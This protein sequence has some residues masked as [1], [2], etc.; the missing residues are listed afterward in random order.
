[1]A[2]M[3]MGIKKAVK[4]GG[5]KVLELGK[6]MI[7]NVSKKMKDSTINTGRGMSFKPAP[8][9]EAKN[10]A[11]KLDHF[12]ETTTLR[13][14][15]NRAAWAKKKNLSEYPHTAK[16]KNVRHAADKYEKRVYQDAHVKLAGLSN[17]R[18]SRV[19]H[20]DSSMKVKRKTI[21]FMKG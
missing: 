20:V 18:N 15:K 9:Q 19:K 16:G 3:A 4:K 1:M 21:K 7:K 13:T 5:S 2:L 12:M 14:G 11:Q 10:Y 8:G 6:K 17:K